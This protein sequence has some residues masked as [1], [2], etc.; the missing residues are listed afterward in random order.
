MADFVAPQFQNPD[1]LGSYLRGQNGALQNQLG[2]QALQGGEQDLVAGGLKLDQ[3]RMAMQSQQMIQ[4]F[5][6]RRLQ[7]Q[8][9]GIGDQPGTPGAAGAGQG[10]AYGPGGGALAPLSPG[11]SQALALLQGRDPDAAYKTSFENQQQQSQLQ[12]KGPIELYDQITGMANPARMVMN[13]PTLVQQWQQYA[14]A[15][16]LDPVNDFNDA[17]VRQAASFAR[18]R[19]AGQVG[20]PTTGAPA[21]LRNVAG[22]NGQMFQVNDQDGGKVTQVTDQKLPAFDIQKRYHP[23]TES[24]SAIPVQTGPGGAPV[25]LGAL[26]GG[27]SLLNHGAPITGNRPSTGAAARRN[28]AGAGSAAGAHNPGNPPGVGNAVPGAGVDLGPEKPT[29]D[30]VQSGSLAL[31]AR[32]GMGSMT[33]LE[34][35]GYRMS[36]TIRA[37]VINAAVSDEPGNIKQWFSQEMVAHGLSAKDQQYTAALMPVLQAAGHSMAGARLTQSQM[38]T[39]FE[40]LIPTESKD[41]GYLDAISTNRKQLYTGLLAQTGAAAEMPEYKDTL[42]ADRK[43]IANSNHAKA[44]ASA[45]AH[46]RANPN[47]APQFK[48]KY[49]YLPGG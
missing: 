3:L 6:A 22:A 47:L 35:S 18:N 42:G 45:I 34:Q 23:E 44:P 15:M 10:V 39:N 12:A 31:Y 25:P 37:A 30:Q 1:L 8:P 48:A 13:N 5:A 11:T 7:P 32:N 16:R 17:N 27:P 33:K 49:G 14:N 36:P 4:K 2:N 21:Q 46:L 38:R 20:L 26:G 9:T 43:A 41:Q 28:V 19:I 24:Y 29:P 40:S